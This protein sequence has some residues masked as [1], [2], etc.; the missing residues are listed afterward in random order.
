[1]KFICRCVQYAPLREVRLEYNPKS[2]AANGRR[3]EVLRNSVVVFRTRRTPVT[4][5]YEVNVNGSATS[6]CFQ[7]RE[8]F[9]A[10]RERSS[11]RK[12]MV[13]TS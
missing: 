8:A 2:N 1:M 9:A 5:T 6:E 10:D 11:V 4:V 12:H 7:A 13:V 3:L